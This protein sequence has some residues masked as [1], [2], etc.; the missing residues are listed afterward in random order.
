[1]SSYAIRRISDRI[2]LEHG[3]A[4]LAPD[5]CAG[6]RQ[7]ADALGHGSPDACALSRTARRRDDLRPGIP[8]HGARLPRLLRDGPV[9]VHPHEPR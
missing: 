1:M 4:P 2:C 8:R 6:R 7:A 9:S 5:V 3:L